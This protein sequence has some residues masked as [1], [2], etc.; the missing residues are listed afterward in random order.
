MRLAV[1]R[2]PS[3][4]THLRST[5]PTLALVGA[6][7]GLAGCDVSLVRGDETTGAAAVAVT[8]TETAA[9]ETTTS[10]EAAATRPSTSVER[11]A[12]D[13]SPTVVINRTRDQYRSRASQI[14]CPTGEVRIDRAVTRVEITEDCAT[15]TL[16]SAASG[17][18]VLAQHIDT[19]RVD[20]QVAVV[21]TSSVDTV[22]I[23]STGT[24]VGWESGTADVTDTGAVNRYGTMEG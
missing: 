22:I 20:A 7:L 9:A 13:Y 1:H 18:V 16:T 3:G 6:A 24:T 2:R 14:S 4:R 23:T 10:V 12:S 21:L 17:S 8:S 11:P 19:L 15:V 5:V